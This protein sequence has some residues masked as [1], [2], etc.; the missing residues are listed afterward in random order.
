M[1]SCVFC[2]CKS[3]WLA[4]SV[5]V[6]GMVCGDCMSEWDSLCD[7]MIASRKA[8]GYPIVGIYAAVTRRLRVRKILARVNV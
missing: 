8:N 5:D 6:M 1:D 3:P 2:K 7:A 4:Y